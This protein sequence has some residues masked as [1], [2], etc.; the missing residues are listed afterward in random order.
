MARYSN[1]S[2]WSAA[3]AGLRNNDY[4]ILAAVAL[5]CLLPVYAGYFSLKHDNIAFDLPMHYFMG[6]ELTAGRAPIWF[7]T[8]N[9]GFPMQSVFCRSI[10]STF[11]LL[12]SWINPSGALIFHLELVFFVALSGITF[13]KLLRGFGTVNRQMARILACAYMLSGFTFGSSQWI[14]YLSGMALMPLCMYFLLQLLHQKNLKYAI[15]LPVSYFVLFTHTHIFMSVVATYLIAGVVVFHCYF[16]LRKFRIS[17]SGFL[18]QS[19]APVLSFLLLI[20]LCAPPVYYSLELLPFLDRSTPITRDLVVFQSDFMHPAGLIT[21]GLPQAANKW[22]IPNTEGLMQSVY[23][24]L[25]VPLVALI[26]FR[27]FFKKPDTL[28]IIL[29]IFSLFFL[30]LS[31]GHL[32]PLRQALNLLP[33]FSYF[34]HP[35]LFRLFFIAFL[36]IFL[37][38][39]T[40]QGLNEIL[41]GAQNRRLIRYYAGGLLIMVSAGLVTGWLFSEDIWKGSVTETLKGA[42]SYSLLL[43]SSVV[44]AGLLAAFLIL[45]R[46][47]R[48]F[49]APLIY[50]DLMLNGLL[51]LP[52]H[53]LSSVPLRTLSAILTPVKGDPVQTEPP[54]SVNAYF[55]DKH[56]LRWEHYNT[57]LKKV[58]ADVDIYNPL[59]GAAV[60]RFLQDA[61]SKSI[62]EGMPFLFFYGKDSTSQAE[63]GYASVLEQTPVRIEAIIQKEVM[64]T[65]CLQQMNFP[66]WNA[67]H[68]GE[69]IPLLNNPGNPFITVFA[70]FSPG[71][72]VLFTYKKPLLVFWAV[73][74]HGIVLLT[75]I[76]ILFGK[77]RYKLI[78]LMR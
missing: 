78:P 34:R 42:D 1:Q 76:V 31:F 62:I 21:L 50:F 59:A 29:I 61:A 3:L 32:L 38:R 70:R 71:D 9:M 53:T 36:L 65:L 35:G 4:F 51:C 39:S 13:C 49:I 33:G 15:L 66:G 68:N 12:F 2:K 73:L 19:L 25:W 75:T 41:T 60:T 46:F 20:L 74:L 64:D 47:R 8:W 55:T 23:M 28:N 37:A 43:L 72:Q 7:N 30:L 44:Q 57:A 17:F 18:K 27:N 5:V 24:G 48:S 58:S 69:E 40:P 11:F 67:Y 63:S 16:S 14:F 77:M 45:W 26:A 6:S 10:F 52:F 54:S 22:Q 56:G